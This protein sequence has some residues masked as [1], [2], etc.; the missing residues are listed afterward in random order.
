MRGVGKSIYEQTGS[1]LNVRSH[2]EFVRSGKICGRGPYN[3][4]INSELS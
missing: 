3:E 4:R 1:A 2:F